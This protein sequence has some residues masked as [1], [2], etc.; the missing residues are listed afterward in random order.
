MR[1]AAVTALVSS[2]GCARGGHATADV[3]ASGPAECPGGACGPL[4]AGVLATGQGSPGALA[5]DETSVYWANASPPAILKCDKRGCGDALIVLAKG[6]WPPVGRLVLHDGDLYWG[7][8]SVIYKC[9]GRIG[10]CAVAGCNESATLVQDYV[11]GPS[12]IA[13][14]DA[15]VYW[16]ELGARAEGG[17][18]STGR[19]V[20]HPK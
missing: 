14:D 2:L 13:V 5:L 4:P 3:A 6:T 16:T 20:F 19:V 17:S 15:N 7:G 11:S 10:K 12:G 1:R 9:A 8:R 18:P